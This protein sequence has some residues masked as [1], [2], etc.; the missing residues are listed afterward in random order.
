MTVER[1]DAAGG[2]EFLRV[3]A[4]L[5]ARMADGFYPVD[6]RLPSQTELAKEFGTSRDTVQR[7]L[8]LLRGEGW[9]ESRQG[10]GSRVVRNQRVQSTTPRASRSQRRLTLGPLIAEA[11]EQDEVTLDVHT[12]TSESLDAHFRVQAE[13]IR[14]KAVAPRRIAVRLI[15]PSSVD[16]LPHPRRLDRKYDGKYDARLRE[17]LRGITETSTAS[18]RKVLDELSA[19]HLVPEVE[20]EFRHAPFA[21]TFKLYLINRCEI[22][23]G[24]YIPLVRP[25]MFDDG[26]EVLALDVLGLGATLT[27]HVRDGRPDSPESTFVD[28]MASWFDATWDLLTDEAGPTPGRG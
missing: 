21:P 13:R 3:A 8:R 27:H 17:R 18:L 6:T 26:E 23:H 1:K 15:L 10:K 20:Y 24:P 4:E 14:S 28:S 16:I 9:I 22:L 25:V 11:F 12:L 7:A 5:R 19:E 2:H